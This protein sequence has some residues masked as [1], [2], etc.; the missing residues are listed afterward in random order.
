MPSVVP[1]LPFFFSVLPWFPRIVSLHHQLCVDT[2]N[3]D[4]WLLLMGT[5]RCTGVFP[6]SF[7]SFMRQTVGPNLHY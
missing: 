3:S 1:D 6:E 4:S 7:V 2:D 5:L